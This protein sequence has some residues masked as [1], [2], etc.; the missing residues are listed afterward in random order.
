MLKDDSGETNSHFSLGLSLR[1]PAA[2]VKRK[3]PASAVGF[4]RAGCHSLSGL[5]LP[6]L[7]AAVGLGLI[8]GLAVVGAR[9]VRLQATAR[10]MVR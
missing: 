3:K 7:W 6:G 2:P 8:F 4:L 9:T 5:F 1:N 10:S